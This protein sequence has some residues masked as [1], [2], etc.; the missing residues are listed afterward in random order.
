MTHVF[1]VVHDRKHILDVSRRAC[2]ISSNDRSRIQNSN[3]YTFQTTRSWLVDWS[4]GGWLENDHWLKIA[5]KTTRQVNKKFVKWSSNAMTASQT[6]LK[7]TT[8]PPRHGNPEEVL[9]TSYSCQ[10]VE[11]IETSIVEHGRSELHVGETACGILFLNDWPDIGYAGTNS[12]DAVADFL[13]LWEQYR[14][15]SAIYNEYKAGPKLSETLC[16]DTW[17]DRKNDQISSKSCV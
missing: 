15:R 16:R 4:T 12:C 5:G 1:C 17:N 6:H 8:D 7:T 10:N 11:W 14:H 3:T 9:V 2:V 13:P